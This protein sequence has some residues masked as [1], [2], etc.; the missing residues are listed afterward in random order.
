MEKNSKYHPKQCLSHVP[1]FPHKI[2]P[3]FVVYMYDNITPTSCNNY[4]YMFREIH[5]GECIQINEAKNQI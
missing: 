3:F 1:I 2:N 4:I 5:N